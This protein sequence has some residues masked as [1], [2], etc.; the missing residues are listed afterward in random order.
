MLFFFDHGTDRL[1]YRPGKPTE[2]KR[3]RNKSPFAYTIGYHHSCPAKSFARLFVSLFDERTVAQSLTVALD[4]SRTWLVFRGFPLFQTTCLC[5]KCLL[6]ARRP[7][8]FPS[9]ST[10]QCT[11][12]ATLLNSALLCLPYSKSVHSGSDSLLDPTS[13]SFAVVSQPANERLDGG[14]VVASLRCTV[15][16]IVTNSAGRFIVARVD[17][18]RI[19]RSSKSS[20]PFSAEKAVG[21]V[22]RCGVVHELFVVADLVMEF[23]ASPRS[24]RLRRNQGPFAHYFTTTALLPDPEIDPYS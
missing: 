24:W 12:E 20:T 14:A 19:T 4:S 16:P 8:R 1:L 21:T 17:I 3:S 11:T 9:W 5:C 7:R 15:L 2:A 22:V 18:L 13:A 6:T 10:R 23:M